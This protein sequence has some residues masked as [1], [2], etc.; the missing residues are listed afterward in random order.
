MIVDV[1]KV[2]ALIAEIAEAE[3]IPRYGKLKAEEIR[4]KAGPHDLVTEVDEATERALE[5]A[6]RGIHPGAGFVGEEL[7][8]KNPAAADVLAGEGVFWVV[9]PLDGTRN[10]V[11]KVDEFGVI[12]ALVEDGETR[13]GW[14]YA[15]PEAASAIAEKGEGAT[16]RGARIAPQDS[17]RD[18][19]I[20]LRSLGWL[21]PQRAD[22]IRTNLRENFESRSN[23]CSAYAYLSLIRGLADFK[24]SSLIHPWDHAA[25]ILM[26]AETGGE[27]A[28]LDDAEPYRP[29]GSIRKP[30]LVSA[31]KGEWEGIAGALL[32]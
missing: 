14:I 27:A 10:F 29:R 3:I 13:A 18:R 28:F 24:I 32:T 5:K 9:D 15:V 6:L 7:A 21:P 19:L 11:N 23:Q 2:A 31:V 4:Q 1:E 26:V 20:G 12:V 25:G 8:A 17:A 22:R 16:W 30:L